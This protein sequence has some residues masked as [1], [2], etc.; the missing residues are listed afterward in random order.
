MLCLDSGHHFHRLWCY[1]CSFDP[2]VHVFVDISSW[3]DKLGKLCFSLIQPC[4]EKIHNVP[5]LS[6]WKICQV[7]KWWHCILMPLTRALSYVL[8]FVPFPVM[9]PVSHALLPFSSPC[10]LLFPQ[11]HPSK[12]SP[13]PPLVIW[14]PKQLFISFHL[15]QKL[16]A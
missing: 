3:E 8:I 16:W 10:K 5:F 9:L 12:D 13:E 14:T 11:T 6:V 15:E 4:L 1:C 2:K 7:R